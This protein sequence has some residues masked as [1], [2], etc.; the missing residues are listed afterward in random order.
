MLLQGSARAGTLLW[1]RRQGNKVRAAKFRSKAAIGL[2]F[3]KGRLVYDHAVPFKYV[4]EELLALSDVTA[5]SVQGVLSKF[6]AA[7]LITKEENAILNRKGY[8][9]AMPEGWDGTDLL[10]RYK[11]AD[12]EIVKN[13]VP[14]EGVTDDDP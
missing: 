13:A 7:A 1:E 8:G 14:L 3:G 5:D 10:A 4:Q 11:A 2:S 9:S 6:C 12:I